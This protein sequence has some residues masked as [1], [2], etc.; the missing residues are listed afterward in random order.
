MLV[1]GQDFSHFNTRYLRSQDYRL[2]TKNVNLSYFE[3]RNSCFFFPWE[4]L[5]LIRIDKTRLRVL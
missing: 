2:K 1:Q 3:N 4:A 5:E